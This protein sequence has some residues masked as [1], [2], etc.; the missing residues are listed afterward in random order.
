[1]T[2]AKKR[3]KLMTSTVKLNYTRMYKPFDLVFLLTL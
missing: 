1:M 3:I 2:T